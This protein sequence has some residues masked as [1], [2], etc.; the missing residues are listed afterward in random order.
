MEKAGTSQ[1]MEK[2]L[3]SGKDRGVSYCYL[4]SSTSQETSSLF[5]LEELLLHS[6]I[7]CQPHHKLDKGNALISD[8][9]MKTVGFIV[10]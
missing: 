7:T 9:L 10:L 2:F 6:Y 5:I 4:S 1:S 3:P 8:W